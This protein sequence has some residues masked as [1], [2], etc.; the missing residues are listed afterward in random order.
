MIVSLIERRLRH[1]MQAQNI[2]SL[3]ILPS[4]LKTKTP[5]WNNLRVFF[6]SV[7]LAK[8]IQD[9]EWRKNNFRMLG[10]SFCRGKSLISVGHVKFCEL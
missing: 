3:A 4:R 7:H 6:S 8:V 1:E 10:Q 5:T 9:K 2:P